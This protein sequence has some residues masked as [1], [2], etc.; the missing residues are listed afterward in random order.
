MAVSNGFALTLGP[1]EVGEETAGQ[2]WITENLKEHKDYLLA[3]EDEEEDEVEQR[4]GALERAQ[5]KF[6]QDLEEVIRTIPD[7]VVRALQVE[8]D[9]C[10]ALGQ[11]AQQQAPG[12]QAD[13]PRQDQPLTGD[14]PGRRLDL[15]CHII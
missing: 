13:Q 3:E 4:L 10:Q 6:H 15:W 2:A 1:S 9:A 12:D 7:M 5:R 14:H 8:R 11:G